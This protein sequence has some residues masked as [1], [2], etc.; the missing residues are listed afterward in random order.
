MQNIFGSGVATGRIAM[1]SSEPLGDPQDQETI[2]VD[3]EAPKHPVGTRKTTTAEAQGKG[4]GEA[5]CTGKRKRGLSEDETQ[6]YGGLTKSVDGLSNAIRAGTPGLYRAVMDVPDFNKDAQMFCLNYLMI[7]K[8]IVETF[9][10]MDDEDKEF[11]MR[12]HM[13]KNNFFG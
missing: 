3:A 5:S 10:E 13:M 9:M 7:N 1:G 11:W 4:Q 8:G 6:L 12:D 2:D